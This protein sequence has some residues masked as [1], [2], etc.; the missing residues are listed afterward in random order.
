MGK[1]PVFALLLEGLPKTFF[2]RTGFVKYTPDETWALA[3]CLAIV[4][5][6][7]EVWLFHQANRSARLEQVRQVRLSPPDA[8]VPIAGIST[9]CTTQ[10]RQAKVFYF[11][12]VYISPHCKYT[13]L[14]VAVPCP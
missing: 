5:T 14:S 8:A 3:V 11:A 13:H 12:V 9:G 1:Y 2:L 4:A 7:R 6:V 10:L